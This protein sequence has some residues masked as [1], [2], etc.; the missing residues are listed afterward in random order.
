MIILGADPGI[1]GGL[2]WLE[3]TP[4]LRR[5]LFSCRMPQL[6]DNEA[7]DAKTIIGL[8]HTHPPDG[9]VLERVHAF[10]RQGVSS[11]FTFGTQFGGLR[12][13]LQIGAADRHIP[14]TLV[15]PATWYRHLGLSADTP[16][17]TQG[18]CKEHLPDLFRF[19]PP[20]CRLIPDG[21][22]DS[23]AIAWWGA[24]T[25]PNTKENP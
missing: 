13:A 18:W 7:V 2:T 17:A 9:I 22:A 10:P 19:L 24:D 23:A 21:M 20:R 25:L 14:V 6:P 5:V 16:R 15:S 4:R 11:M 8:M 12:A 3:M 1:H